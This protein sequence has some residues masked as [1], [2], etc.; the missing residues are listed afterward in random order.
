MPVLY[1]N[2][3][4]RRAVKPASRQDEAELPGPVKLPDS[5]LLAHVIATTSGDFRVCHDS[6]WLVLR[7][8]GCR[9]FVPG[10]PR[11]RRAQSKS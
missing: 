5:R 7:R 3:K 1:L 10:F 8:N 6:T 4:A 9:K 11:I 2:D